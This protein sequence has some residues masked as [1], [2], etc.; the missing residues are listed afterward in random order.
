[1]HTID[2]TNPDLS[3]LS[4]HLKLGG[5]NPQ[6]V[7]INA[8]SR[9]LTLDGAPWLPVMGEFHY[10]RYPN[11]D[12]RDELLRMKAGGI[13]IAATYVFWI[14]HEEIEGQFNWQGNLDLRRFVSLCGEVGLYAYPRIGPWAHGECRNGGFPDWLVTRFGDRLRSDDRG[15]LAYVRRLY[16]EI[17]AQLQG[18]LWKDGGPV[19]GVQLEN[20]LTNNARHILTLKRLAQEVGLDVPLY[21]MTGW[22]PAQVPEDE[23]IPLFGGYPDAFWDR[24]VEEWSQSSRKHYFFSHLRDDNTIGADLHRAEGIPD[25]SYL[26]R[27][28]FAT[29]ELGGGMQVSYHRRPWIAPGDVAA[30]ALTRIGSG[31]NLPGYYMYHGGSNPLGQLSTLQESQAT[32]Y[33]NDVPVI[34]YDF[35]AP[36]REY[37]QVSLSYHLLRSLHLFL[38]DYGSQLAPMPSILPEDR[39][40]SLDD[41]T[42]LRWA[43]RSDGHSGFIF[44]STYQRIEGLSPQ[45]GIQLELNLKD[46]ALIVPTRPV[47]IPAGEILVWPFNLDLNGVLL[48]HST[49]QPVC[50]LEING[51]PCYVFAACKGVEPEFVFDARTLAAT[52]GQAGK[53]PLPLRLVLRGM[54]MGTGSAFVLQ[55]A[56]GRR[57]QVLLLS[58]AE[59]RLCWKA[60][61]W[62]QERIFISP[63]S[64]IIESSQVRMRAR[65]PESLWFAV[66]PPPD[67]DLNQGNEPLTGIPDG[68]FTRYTAGVPEASVQV[69]VRKIKEAAPARR[70]PTGP[71]GVAQAPE[72]VDFAGAAEWEVRFPEGMLDG[73]RE[74][75]LQVDYAGDAARGLPGGPPGGG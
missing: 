32:G 53:G 33:W 58:P 1:M 70:V 21:T 61:V 72:E 44:I 48:K 67:C 49:C 25:L 54:A 38:A 51:L 56:D 62:G 35:Q 28:P 59:G 68:N 13:Q 69:E 11:Q 31:S 26:E 40:I 15:Y 6:G 9:F 3:Y 23:V 27:Y 55:A 22:G 8:N 12:W 42:T 47:D 4:G 24:Q 36:L 16:Q 63:A 39:P 2:L 66:Y 45:E 41:R 75:F 73:A 10:S 43:S 57:A 71:L 65:K 5:K 19:I 50:Q 64:L 34:S 18:L 46:E 60:Q 20:E 7:E 37:G 30:M 52:A 74:V 17:A 29:C 14:H